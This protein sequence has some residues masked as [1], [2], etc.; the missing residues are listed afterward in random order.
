MMFI[1][2]LGGSHNINRFA[3]VP[4]KAPIMN[5]G[6]RQLQDLMLIKLLHGGK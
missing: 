4:P 1:N 3:I 6:F 5:V 2:T